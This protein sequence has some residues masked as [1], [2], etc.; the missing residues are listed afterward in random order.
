MIQQQFDGELLLA[1]LEALAE[2]GFDAATGGMQRVAY[3]TADLV[4]RDW[5]RQQMH[6]LGLL[7]RDDE[8]GNT[9]GTLAGTDSTLLSIA[10]GSHTDTVPNGGKY[11]G[12]L[13]VLAALA[14]VRTL[15]TAGH[16]LRH[17]VEVINFA[18]E[19]ATMGG[20]TTGSR[21]MAGVYDTAVLQKP[22]WNGRLVGDIL[23][24]AGLNPA[25]IMNAQR[26]KGSLAAYV[27]LH[28]EQGDAL[29]KSET[30]VGI[31]TGIVGIRRY[32][33][34][35]PGYANHAGTTPMDS[36]QDALWLASPYILQ[37][38]DIAMSHGIVG[39]IGQVE[40]FP[41]APNVIPERVDLTVE[42]R[43]LEPE[44]LDTAEQQLE[45]VATAVH[46]TFTATERKP[47]IASDPRIID[48]ITGACT[49]LS[50]SHAT[51]PSGAGHDPMNIGHLCPVGMLFVPS[52][53]GVSHSPDEYTTP[54]DCIN[55]GR[56]LLETLVRLDKALP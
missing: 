16:T 38:R 41:G 49:A 4:G 15:K 46:A 9:I 37:V 13:G 23:R 34:S 2:I 26:E 50:L 56:V 51:M 31:V 14:A 43:G 54:E 33:V 40:V 11:D 55:G 28:I 6:D 25:T 36:R 20:G 35:F 10:I 19:E 17:S 39:T 7:V 27:E 30:A 48:I 45:E 24:E 21:V 44:V 47:P 1:D 52:Q 53:G 22:A 29:V 32:R 18:A 12:S 8:A 5:V 3:G 42:I